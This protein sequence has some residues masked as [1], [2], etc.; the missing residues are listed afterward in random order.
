MRELQTKFPRGKVVRDRYIVEELLGQGGFG[1]VYRVRDRRVKSNIF[2]LKEITHPNRNQ[3]ESFA[4]EGEILRRL[5]HYALPRVY[6]V[7]EDAK[8][9]RLCMLMDYI[10]G[11]NLERLRVQQPEKRFP[12]SQVLHMMAPIIDAV[13]YLH[14]QQPPIIHRDIKPSNIIV[15]TSGESAFLVDFGIAKEFDQDSTT[16]AVRHCS[17]GYG[18]PEQYMSGTS[19]HTDVYG[20]AATFYTLLTGEVPIDALYRITRLSGKRPD[21]LELASEL[22]PTIPVPIAEALQQAM[23]VNSNDRFATVEE[24][25]ET[26]RSYPI[27]EPA[28]DPVVEQVKLSAATPQQDV[29]GMLGSFSALAPDT[30][31]AL[32]PVK[33]LPAAVMQTPEHARKRPSR[34]LYAVVTVVLFV[35]VVGGAFL[36]AG[37]LG[38]KSASNLQAQHA[39][40]SSNTQPTVQPAVTT[41]VQPTSVPPTPTSVPPTPTMVEVA[42]TAPALREVT[43]APVVAPVASFPLLTSSY[44]GPIHNTPAVVDST[45]IIAQLRQSQGNISGVLSLGPG[46]LGNGNFTG[47]VTEDKKLQFLV[48][49]HSVLLPL[50]FQGQI[51]ADGSISGTYCS[52]QNGQCNFGGGGYGTWHVFPASITS[53]RP[54]RSRPAYGLG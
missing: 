19:T 3:R 30:P 7:F 5:D 9:N 54:I 11:P 15:P 8:N 20:L 52:Y 46:L 34:L 26:L 32:S 4:F 23:A 13:I 31:L 1:A 29:V 6:R 43:P 14:K 49:S 16:T 36:S 12:L 41:H 38:A 18:A 24:M 50:Y 53:E 48:P 35:F 51:L 33:K 21:P 2:A 40:V 17:P 37:W 44:S 42:P 45:V 28:T 39:S 25:W 27:E 47:T 22:V 10:E